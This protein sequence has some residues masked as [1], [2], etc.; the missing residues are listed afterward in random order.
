MLLVTQ[1]DCGHRHT[2]V[3]EELAELKGVIRKHAIWSLQT[4]SHCK[5]LERQMQCFRGQAPADLVVLAQLLHSES[6]SVT[7]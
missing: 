2:G 5:A 1:T 7:L 3:Q 4:A 6:P